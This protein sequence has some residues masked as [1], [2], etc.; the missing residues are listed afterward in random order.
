MNIVIYARYSSSGQ[1]EESIE[2]QLKACYE[3]AINN[4]YNVIAEYI[5]R[6]A[7]AT[8]DQR[9]QFQ[10][11]MEDSEKKM[12]QGVLVYQLDRFARNRYDSAI[13][14]SRLKKNGIRVLSAKE[15]I[16]DDPSGIILEG[17]LETMAEYFSAD[18]SQKTRRG[19]HTNAEKCKYNGGPVPLGYRIDEEKRFQIDENTA[20]I[21]KMVFER[22]AHG[23]PIVEI[24]DELNAN[25]LKT[26]RGT[27]FNKN[28]FRKMLSNKRYTGVYVY[29]GIETADGIP[30]IIDDDLFLEVQERMKKN[31]ASK[32]TTGQYLLTTKLFCGYCHNMM[33]GVSGTS[34]TGAVHNY[35]ACS[36]SRQKQCNKKN[37]KRDFIEDLVIRECRKC[38]TDENI[39]K[40]AK[41]VSALC[42]K[43]ANSPYV[44][45]LKAELSQSKTAIEN[46]LKA[47][48]SGVETD[49]VLERIRE[50]REEK[51]HIE[52][53][54]AKE[55]L[56]K[57]ILTEPEITF[58]LTQL[59]TGNLDKEKY[60]KA[61]INVFVNQI[62]LYD[63]KM[64]IIFN[65]GDKTVTIHKELLGDLLSEQGSYGEES[66]IPKTIRKPLKF[67]WFSALS[68]LF[69][70]QN[71]PHGLKDKKGL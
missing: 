13:N 7:T 58:F 23:I 42:E 63:D 50:R 14:K 33:V 40:I 5:D 37:V 28:S 60:R 46:L 71:R 69:E 26:S 32:S 64:A 55:Q 10:Q 31:K 4:N 2:G 25:H 66:G 8:N 44:Q 20:P 52:A 41:E 18:L 21:V 24:I 47:L 65:C 56:V 67:Q 9:L 49:T 61:L 48:E 6:A 70:V 51:E 27:A 16:S 36:K 30:R 1:R 11:M 59:K 34:H 45:Q 53:Q 22:Y 19:H 43:E 62:Y 39:S 17:M 57:T 3:Y 68:D 54:L 12:F 29:D 15:N 35:Y 38:L